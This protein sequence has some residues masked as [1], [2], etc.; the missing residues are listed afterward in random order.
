MR[1]FSP[2]GCRFANL[3]KELGNSDEVANLPHAVYQW[4][5]A[6]P[7]L[8][9]WFFPQPKMLKPLLVFPLFLMA[10]MTAMVALSMSMSLSA[11]V[12][13]LILHENAER[14]FDLPKDSVAP[15]DSTANQRM[16]PA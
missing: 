5:T 9:A 16:N 8:V 13:R 14:L 12:V 10:S 6:L 2:V 1:I 7:I 4:L 11:R 15:T 3:L